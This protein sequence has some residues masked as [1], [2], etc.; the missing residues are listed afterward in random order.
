MLYKRVL[1]AVA[2][3]PLFLLAVWYGG[4]VHFALTVL[5]MV[6]ALYE[7]NKIF[8][9]MDLKPSFPVMVSGV[10]ILSASAYAG[11]NGALGLA[12]VPVIGI[13]LLS[14]VFRYPDVRPVD[15]AAGLTGTLY[16]GMFVYFYL[17]R[18]LEGG[19]VWTLTMLVGTWAGDTAAYFVGRKMGRKKLAPKLSPGK[20]VEG[21]I[22]GIA[23]SVL[24]ALLI[25]MVYPWYLFYKFIALGVLVGVSGILGDLF[26]SSLKRTA[27]VKDAGLIIPGHGGVLDRFDSMLFTAPTVYYFV[28]LFIVG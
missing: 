17:V 10:L 2:G 4:W 7:L 1:S 14:G 6:F 18:T 21:A 11:G 22:G 19:W 16:I 8:T 23:G 20:T 28:V 27:G 13:L 24:G 25:Y 5:I 12:F 15:V 9:G 3:I 26:E